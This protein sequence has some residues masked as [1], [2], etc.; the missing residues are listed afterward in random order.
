MRRRSFLAW[1][2]RCASALAALRAW[3]GRVLAGAPSPT[4]ASDPLFDALGFFTTEQAVTM[5]AMVE[6][7]LPSDVPAGTPGAR[8]TRVLRYLDRQLGTPRFPEYREVFRDGLAALDDIARAKNA[9]RFHE[10]PAGEQDETLRRIQRGDSQGRPAASVRFFQV[11]LTLTLEG[12]W[13]SPKHGGNHD[14]RAWRSV[15][16]HPDC[17][18][19]GRD[20][21]PHP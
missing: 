17:D 18:G 5:E 20:D 2:M 7:L 19:D 15:G 3:P 21:V 14:A 10:L 9:V 11:T 16:L 4:P 1:I 8:E 13:G 12:H 6:R